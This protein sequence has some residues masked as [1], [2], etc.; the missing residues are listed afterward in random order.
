MTTCEKIDLHLNLHLV[1]F[2]KLLYPLSVNV[3]YTPYDTVVII[4]LYFLFHF[5]ATAWN[6]LQNGIQVLLIWL[7][8]SWEIALQS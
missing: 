1:Y 4:D 6:F 7:I 5:R 8:H 3:E 2:Y